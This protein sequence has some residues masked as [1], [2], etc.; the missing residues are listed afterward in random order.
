MG[1]LTDKDIKRIGE[2]VGRVIEDNILPL[3]DEKIEEKLGP[4][5]SE[6][7]TIKSNITAINATMVTKDYL[8]EKLGVTNGKVARLVNVLQEKRVITEADKTRVLS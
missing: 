1:M 5:N 2:E 3:I 4:V 8:D 7:A 6:I